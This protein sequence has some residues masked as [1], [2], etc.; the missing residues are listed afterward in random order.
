MLK[1]NLKIDNSR[2]LR[3]PYISTR[4]STGKPYLSTRAD[5]R[6]P[7][8]SQCERGSKE[9]IRRDVTLEKSK[10]SSVKERCRK[11]FLMS[12]ILYDKNAQHGDGV[13]TTFKDLGL[14]MWIVS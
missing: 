4:A 7:D 6:K 10:L 3:K 12:Y 13:D 5:S 2:Q 14:I 11:R 1:N 9:K 8:L